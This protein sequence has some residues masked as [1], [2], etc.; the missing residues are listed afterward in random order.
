LE[1][2]Q[3]RKPLNGSSVTKKPMK[4]SIQVNAVANVFRSLWPAGL[5]IITTPLV[6]HRLGA[7]PYGLFTVTGSL[8]NLISFLN[9]GFNDALIKHL[10]GARAADNDR[11]G[12]DLFQTNL[13]LFVMLGV[14]IS[15]L[16]MILAPWLVRVVLNPPDMLKTKAQWTV[17]ILGITLALSFL[18]GSF[19]A[20]IAAAE[21]YDLLALLGVVFSTVSAIG[22]IAIVLIYP[23]IVILSVW[24][25]V[26]ALIYLRLQVRVFSY[27]YPDIPLKL[28]FSGEA[29]DLLWKFS[30][31][32]ILDALFAIGF[33]QFD[34]ILVN[35]FV[36]IASV[37]YYTIPSTFA[38]FIGHGSNAITGPLIP[39]MSAADTSRQYARCNSLYLNSI[40]IMS[41]IIL[42]GMVV[43]S[44]LSNPILR[45]WMG[46]EFAAHTTMVFVSLVLAWGVSA[47]GVVAANTLFG[48]GLPRVNMFC[49]AIQTGV[50]LVGIVLLVPI[51]GV[52]GSGWGFLLG[53]VIVLALSVVYASKAVRC[54]L[55][56]TVVL[57]FLP[58]IGIAL[59]I[60]PV[61][62]LIAPSAKSFLSLVGVAS[63]VISF[64]IV[65]GMLF[66][67]VD[68]RTVVR[69][70]T[71]ST[72][73]A[74]LRVIIRAEYWKG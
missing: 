65:L 53:N 16:S 7:A 72:K 44:A 61:A 12:R 66:G 57:G 26:A 36:G 42:T 39:A 11:L 71:Q 30:V 9:V 4:S 13:F 19:G 24:C 47:L 1:I 74:L 41:W 69:K 60:L 8:V 33:M 58:S 62:F 25:L 20:A 22:Q 2:S 73:E 45:V 29:F 35:S 67:I 50:G 40:R 31:Y 34:R 63:I 37:I 48:L 49:R 54:P 10:A 70:V 23:D 46:A 32:R 28:Y 14:V 68:Y 51:Y 52:E 5:A 6:V 27:L 56:K 43:L 21:R 18:S 15:I 64:S 3:N 59:C 38:Q 55:G 17:L